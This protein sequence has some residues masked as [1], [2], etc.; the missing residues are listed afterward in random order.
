MYIDNIQMSLNSIHRS[1]QTYGVNS[2]RVYELIKRRDR[3]MIITG[4][5]LR[6]VIS[7]LKR[8][9]DECDKK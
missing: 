8:L 9:L 2:D 6:I 1:V 4:D 7:Q 3:M 5:G